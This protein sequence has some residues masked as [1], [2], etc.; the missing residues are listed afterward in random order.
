M[1]FTAKRLRNFVLIVDL[2]SGKPTQAHWDQQLELIATAR[3]E[4]APLR[5]LVY[6]TSEGPD[7]LQ[8]ESLR[9]AL[10][11]VESPRA[12]V[13]TDSVFVRSIMRTVGWVARLDV[14]PFKPTDLPGALEYLQLDPDQR[15]LAE[16]N[17]PR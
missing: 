7:N 9:A 15:H 11:G 12:A 10:A 3:T 1:S 4:P 14:R 8:R 17:V 2:G 16:R 5:G 6:T 13:M